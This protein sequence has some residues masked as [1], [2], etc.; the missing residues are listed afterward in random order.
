MMS[1]VTQC[2]SDPVRIAVRTT[3]EI[4]SLPAYPIPDWCD[5]A[6]VALSGLA[7]GPELSTLVCP[8]DSVGTPGQV[9]IAGATASEISRVGQAP[10]SRSPLGWTAP[11]PVSFA[12]PRTFRVSAT[13][14]YPAWASSERGTAWKNL[15]AT[16]LMVG[17][18]EIPGGNRR[19]VV[20]EVGLTPQSVGSAGLSGR[21]LEGVLPLLV[22]RLVM[23]FGRDAIS[24][25]S[26]LT[27]R[28]QEVIEQ[29]VAGRTV[30]EIAEILGRSPHTVHDHVKSLHRK[31]N[32]STRGELVARALGFVPPRESGK[33][34]RTPSRTHVNGDAGA[35]AAIG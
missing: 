21:V 14:F 34:T 35:H 11:P 29:L 10:M 27:A 18:A 6:A 31:F 15:G 32:A 24:S 19:C 13:P 7:A 22:D 9:E 5:R 8:L 28:E 23:A 33:A 2:D 12:S 17:L 30:R 3:S 4:C 16:D 25:A 1:N 20:I 26:L